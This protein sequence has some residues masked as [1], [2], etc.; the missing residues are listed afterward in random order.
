M[1]TVA[2]GIKRTIS[3]NRNTGNE[4][5]HIGDTVVQNG[6]HKNVAES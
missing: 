2:N 5:N 4:D 1:D 3:D 6:T